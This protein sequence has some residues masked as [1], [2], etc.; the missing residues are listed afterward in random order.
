M[1]GGRWNEFLRRGADHEKT[2]IAAANQLPFSGVTDSDDT[3][4]SLYGDLAAEFFV[5]K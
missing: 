2:P 3:Y 1:T 4:Q 5:G